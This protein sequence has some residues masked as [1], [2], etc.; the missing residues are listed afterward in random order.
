[1]AE[2]KSGLLLSRNLSNE[3]CCVTV[4]LRFGGLAMNVRQIFCCIAL[5]LS[6]SVAAA[7]TCFETSIMSP[8]PFMGNHGE[9]F[10][11]ADGSLWEVQ[12]EYEYLYEYYPSVIICPSRGKLAIK[13]KTLNIA[14]VGSGRSVGNRGKAASGGTSNFIESRIDGAF[15]GWDGE[16]IFKLVNGQIWQQATYAYTYSYK[17][18]PRV[19]IFRTS[20]GHEMQVE[21]MDRRITVVRIR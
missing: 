4:E 19:M 2:E 7:Q 20:G 8:S 3:E 18:M 16:T 5:A 14:Q 9:I 10:K 15:N 21:G 12:H 11:T 6:T 13:D 1:M 17:Y